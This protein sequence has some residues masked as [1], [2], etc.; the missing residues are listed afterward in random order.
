MPLSL[1]HYT[2]ISD[3]NFFLHPFFFLCVCEDEEEEDEENIS[4]SQEDI[5]Y[6]LQS[7]NTYSISEFPHTTLFTLL[8]AN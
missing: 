8:L 3:D 5:S 1:R 2:S 7:H 6:K 4:K